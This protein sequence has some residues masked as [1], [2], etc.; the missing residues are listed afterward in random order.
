MIKNLYD[1]V[2]N[3]STMTIDNLMLC[4]RFHRTMIMYFIV[5]ITLQQFFKQ[6]TFLKFVFTPQKTTE[7]LKDKMSDYLA[8][9]SES[10]LS[11]NRVH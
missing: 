2:D 10:Y 5:M 9:F 7:I 4:K 1:D 8:A 6:E 11:D 3:N